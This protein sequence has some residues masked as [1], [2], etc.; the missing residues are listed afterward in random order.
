MSY[1]EGNKTFEV[2][3][4]AVSNK[5]LVKLSGEKILHNTVTSTDEPI[6]ASLYQ[7]AVGDEIAVSL[8]PGAKTI[9][10]TASEAIAAGVDCYAAADGKVSTLPA[11]AGDYKKVGKSMK[12]ASGD[13]SIFEMLPYPAFTITTV[14]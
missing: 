14:P 6:G 9:E 13:G 8:L 5:R 7:G 3:T 4:A 11:G 1:N 12:P 2:V 10:V